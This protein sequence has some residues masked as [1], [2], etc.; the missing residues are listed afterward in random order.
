MLILPVSFCQDDER[1]R[2]RGCLVVM[3]PGDTGS[4]RNSQWRPNQC[5]TKDWDD[6]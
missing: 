6:A 2:S 5:M 3:T 1:I 4:I